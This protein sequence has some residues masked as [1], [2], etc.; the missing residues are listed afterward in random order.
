M[1]GGVLRSEAMM[2]KFRL[3]SI[4]SIIF[5]TIGFW[6]YRL[7]NYD[8]FYFSSMRMFFLC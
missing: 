4:Y 2:P 3:P 8:N 5:L 1:R 7:C 6:P